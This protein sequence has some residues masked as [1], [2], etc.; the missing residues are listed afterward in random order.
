MQDFIRIPN[1]AYCTFG[2]NGVLPANKQVI[3]LIDRNYFEI[4]AI[5]IQLT[6][7]EITRM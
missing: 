5:R 4:A 6:L 1:Y 2:S 7:K 3:Y